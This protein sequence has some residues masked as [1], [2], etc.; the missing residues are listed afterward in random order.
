MDDSLL[1]L[2]VCPITHSKLK[3]EGEWLVSVEGG[4]KDPVKEGLPVLLPEAAVVPAPYRTVEEFRA[5]M[6]G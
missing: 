5:A 2:V 1:E 4:V 3:R 6:K